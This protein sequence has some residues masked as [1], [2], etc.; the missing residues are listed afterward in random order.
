VN[1]QYDAKLF[2]GLVPKL[3]RVGEWKL[4]YRSALVGNNYNNSNCWL[5][6]VICMDNAFIDKS[7]K[8]RISFIVRIQ[9]TFVIKRIKLKI[10]N[11]FIDL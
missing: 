4:S 6:K 8:A 11:N 3:N 9:K 2:R 10:L 5:I 1:I 7:I